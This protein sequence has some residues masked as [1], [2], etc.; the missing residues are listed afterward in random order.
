MKVTCT[1]GGGVSFPELRDAKGEVLFP[2]LRLRKGDNEVSEEHLYA[3]EKHCNP[4]WFEEICKSLEV[5]ESDDDGP[6]PMNAADKIDVVK[7]AETLAELEGLAD[8]EERKTVLAAIDKRLE[9]LEAE[10]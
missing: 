7:E 8:G 6:A 9:E 2:R 10:E 5:G 3:L 4:A 1:L